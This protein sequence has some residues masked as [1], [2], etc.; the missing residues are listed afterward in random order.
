MLKSS[1]TFLLLVSLLFINCIGEDVIDD[2]VEPEV[3]IT[4]FI[5]E[6]EIS[7]TYQFTV[8]YFNNVGQE[9]NVPVTWA[10]FSI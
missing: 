10:C 5:T 3:R 7:N 8:T 2:F 4:N 6:I 9:E 1:T